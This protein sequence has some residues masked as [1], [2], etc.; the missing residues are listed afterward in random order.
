[1][2]GPARVAEAFEVH[3]DNAARNKHYHI[4]A[5][6]SNIYNGGEKHIRGHSDEDVPFKMAT[7]VAEVHKALGSVGKMC[8]MD[9][10]VVHM[11]TGCHM[12]GKKEA[13]MLQAMIDRIKDKSVK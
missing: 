1:M 4:A 5:H 13:D 8:D 12:F 10:V 9:N 2:V 3:D 6:G 7:Q 11:K